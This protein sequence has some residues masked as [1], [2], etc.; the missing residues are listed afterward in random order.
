MHRWLYLEGEGRRDRPYSKRQEQ[1]KV[2][3]LPKVGLLDI[4]LQGEEGARKQ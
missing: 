2:K 3:V 4:F 1:S